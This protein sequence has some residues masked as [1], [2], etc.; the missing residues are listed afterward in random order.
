MIAGRGNE[1]SISTTTLDL[2]NQPRYLP[3]RVQW[4]ASIF[5]FQKNPIVWW[6]W[7]GE[8]SI[9][10]INLGNPY[11]TA[12]KNYLGKNIVY[13]IGH[14][15]TYKKTKHKWRWSYFV[16]LLWAFYITLVNQY[17]GVFSWNPKGDYY[18]LRLVDIII[19]ILMII[20]TKKS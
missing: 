2:H 19:A 18:L 14:R 11:M 8:T 9:I 4:L 16:A 1:C 13:I 17:P 5:S 6:F 10:R 15:G 7:T 12:S 3:H 20:K